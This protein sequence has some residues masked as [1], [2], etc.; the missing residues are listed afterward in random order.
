[1]KTPLDHPWILIIES[2]AVERYKGR[3][4]RPQPIIYRSQ[5]VGTTSAVQGRTHNTIVVGLE[6]TVNG[7]RVYC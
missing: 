7:V 4:F 1:M 2:P 3:D 6:F 5:V